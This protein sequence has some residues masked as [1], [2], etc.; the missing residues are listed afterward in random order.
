V[1]PRGVQRDDLDIAI[2]GLGTLL[3]KAH[4][5]DQYWHNI[6]EQVCVLGEVPES[7]WDWKLYFDADRRAS[8][9]VTVVASSVPNVRPG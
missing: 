1:G 3:P 2:V 7:R 6:L 4:D 5:A 9:P 8:G